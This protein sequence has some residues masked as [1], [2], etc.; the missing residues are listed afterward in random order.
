MLGK[1]LGSHS[2]R[3]A[4][5]CTGWKTRFVSS[6]LLTICDANEPAQRQRLTI[7]DKD[8]PDKIEFLH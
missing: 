6:P 1:K 7:G 3:V 5:A 8:H 2:L 4:E